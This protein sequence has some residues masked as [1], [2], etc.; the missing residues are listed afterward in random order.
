MLQSFYAAQET[1]NDSV[2]SLMDAQGVTVA[3]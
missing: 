3:P 1:V 2:G